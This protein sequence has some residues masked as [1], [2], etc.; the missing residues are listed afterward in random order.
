MIST[1]YQGKYHHFL[2]K[3]VILDSLNGEIVHKKVDFIDLCS[4]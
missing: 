1:F 2:L 4:F 3:V